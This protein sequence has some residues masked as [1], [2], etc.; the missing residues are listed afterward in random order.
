MTFGSISVDSDRYI[1]IPIVVNG[2]HSQNYE[3]SP[4]N[5]SPANAKQWLE[6][7][8]DKRWWKAEYNSDFMNAV[9]FVANG[10]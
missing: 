2:R 5:V 8:Q 1:I 9:N 7:L 6:H 3:I 4:L 10:R